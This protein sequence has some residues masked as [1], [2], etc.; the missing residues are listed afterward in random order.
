MMLVQNSLFWR[1]VWRTT[2]IQLHLQHAKAACTNLLAVNNKSKT[3][4]CLLIRN[5][6]NVK[7][8]PDLVKKA[9][10]RLG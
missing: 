7:P 8:P 1:E 5:S 6:F 4:T 3:I 10:E 2:I 9:L